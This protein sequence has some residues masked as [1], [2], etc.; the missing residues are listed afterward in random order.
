MSNSISSEDPYQALFLELAEIVNSLSVEKRA[1]IRTQL[2]EYTHDLKDLL[3]L[4]TGANA[5]LKRYAAS[6]EMDPQVME[7][8]VLIG[9]ISMKIDE[10]MDL[11]T[12]YLS[13]QI[14]IEEK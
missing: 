10:H 4:V 7:M 9:D 1:S 3:G 2:G 5:L 14:M 13:Q 8:V 6:D 11:L 12:K